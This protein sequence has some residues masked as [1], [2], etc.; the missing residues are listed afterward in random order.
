[1]RKKLID[2]VS[3][4]LS[5][6][7]V[8]LLILEITFGLFIVLVSVYLFAEIAEDVWSNETIFFD[9]SI[10]SLI[11][12]TRNS[13]L[14]EWMLMI[15]QLGGQYFLGTAIILTITFLLLSKHVKDALIFS[16]IL[17]F[18]IVLNAALKIIF[19]RERPTL[20][21]LAN[22]SSFSF[23]SAHTMNSFIFFT[24]LSYFIFRKMKHK[25]SKYTFISLSI[26][27]VILI[28]VSRIY[29][30]VHF[31]SDVI[32][33]YVAGLCWFVLVILFEKTLLFLN[34]FKRYEFEKKY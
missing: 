22:E 24:C 15:T 13:V 23:P 3:F 14:T 26:L 19:Q 29:L 28:G 1:M 16:F 18:G 21:P 2:I 10:T 6:Y 32:A 34:M 33:G 11:Y 30:G 25:K 20:L 31:P 27:L 12:L 17:F 9:Q 5:S 8:F 4:S 7:S